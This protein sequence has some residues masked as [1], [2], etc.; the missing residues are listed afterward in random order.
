[1]TDPAVLVL[2]LLVV[3]YALVS[4]RLAR[5]VVT[6]AMAFAAAGLVAGPHVLAI[7]D[8]PV[9][10]EAFKAVADLALTVLLFTEA[11]RL[12]LAA[13]LRGRELPLRLLGIGLPLTMVAGTVLALLLFPALGF[14]EAAA[15]AVVLAPTDAA[16]GEAVVLD[17][18]V[19]G[20]V[21]RS[22]SAESGLN[23]GLALPF[24]IIALAFA[25]QGADG[26]TVG[27]WIWFIVRTVGVSVIVGAAIGAAGG[28][29]MA[30]GLRA[31]S[32]V[33]R[34]AELSILALAV[35]SFVVVEHVD[36]SGFVGAFVAGIAL[37][38]V[39]PR[40]AAGEEATATALG[41]LLALVVF[42]FFGAAILWPAFENIDVRVIVYA[43]L[44]LTFV[45]IVP[46]AISL[47]GGGF[48]R[49]TSL[50][51]GWFGPRGI[52]SL[53]FAVVLVEEADLPGTALILQTVAVTVAISIVAH[54]VTAPWGAGSYARA[55]DALRR[56]RPAAA[57]LEEEPAS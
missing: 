15:L 30:R 8:V 47:V 28:W 19:P 45:R 7:F 6:P 5:S 33:E 27:H 46:V 24:L 55:I 16:L 29:L 2:C 41:Q 48:T 52:A 50:F 20:V 49:A 31:G 23:D 56:T 34:F 53:I 43:V 37:G 51:I 1:M 38:A 10:G 4:A 32:M 21:R 42:A 26:G 25:E 54:G 18:R 35:L 14:W 39:A 17:S 3:A 11:S 13:L 36:G 12:D 9:D 22:L 40:V 57:E 44:S